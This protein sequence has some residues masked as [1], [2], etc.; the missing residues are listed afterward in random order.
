MAAAAR[1]PRHLAPTQLSLPFH[2]PPSPPSVVLVFCLHQT[3]SILSPPPQKGPHNRPPRQSFSSCQKLRHNS[4]TQIILPSS[5]PALGFHS[6][7]RAR[8]PTH[9]QL[10]HSLTFDQNDH[11]L[12][13]SPLYHPFN[14]RRCSAIKKLKQ[15]T[16]SAFFNL[17]DFA[18]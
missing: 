3:S 5:K 1:L 6:I 13:S 4:T 8:H 7:F 2:L 14:Y 15:V 16:T 12:H 17:F 11:V 18:V 9:S 10:P